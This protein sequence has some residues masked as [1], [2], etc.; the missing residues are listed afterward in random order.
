ML[1]RVV[2]LRSAARFGANLRVAAP[3]ARSLH[4]TGARFADE[5]S[6]PA[7][8]LNFTLPSRAL[9]VESQVAMVMLPGDDGVFGVMPS[10][11]PTVAQLKPGLVQVMETEGAPLKKYFISGGFATMSPESV[12]NIS[13]LEAASLEDIDADAVKVGLAQYSEAYANA[14]DDLLKSEAEIGVEV[15]Q[16]LSH[17]LAEA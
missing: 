2:A 6:G 1:S 8:T 4:A 14:T 17:S 16:A 15:Y 13:T 7:V 9:Y 5:V 3:A 12:L 10:H 11:V